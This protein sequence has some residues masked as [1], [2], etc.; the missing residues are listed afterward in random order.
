MTSWLYS[1]K[2]WDQTREG[3]S[4]S[5]YEQGWLFWFS[6]GCEWDEGGGRGRVWSPGLS[7]GNEDRRGEKEEVGRLVRR[8]SRQLKG[9]LEAS[10]LVLFL[11]GRMRQMA[12]PLWASISLSVK[13]G[14]TIANPAS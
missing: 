13:M 1:K 11:L 12:S 8:A 3:T 2:N 5:L 9:A 4:H 10:F 6:T 7:S 14:D